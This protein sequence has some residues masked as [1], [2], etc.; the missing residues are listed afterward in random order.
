MNEIQGIERLKILDGKLEEFKHVLDLCVQAVRKKDIGTLQ[1]EAYFNID[2]T[3][4]IILERYRD[5]ESLLDHQKNL[6]KLTTA[7]LKT[8]TGSGA[9][10]G[11]ASPELLK[12]LKG[13][14]VRYFS[15]YQSLTP[16][17]EFQG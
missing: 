17:N 15:P 10:C 7:L 9:V 13:S 6:D 14:A 1:Y 2:Q 4:C 3:E 16:L 12:S 11:K 5:S 8:C